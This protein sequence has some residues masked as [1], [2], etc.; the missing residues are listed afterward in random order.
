MTIARPVVAAAVVPVCRNPRSRRFGAQALC[1]HPHQPTTGP[2]SSNPFSLVCQ[3]DP[4]RQ[5]ASISLNKRLHRRSQSAVR[6]SP[7]RPGGQ[8]FRTA[9]PGR[10]HIC[11]Q[12]RP[13]RVAAQRNNTKYCTYELKDEIC[14]S[15]AF[16]SKTRASGDRAGSAD[17]RGRCMSVVRFCVGVS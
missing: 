3:H 2:Q 13:T 10:Q 14:D 4:H 7:G 6:G 16:V 15:R 17:V 11:R 9:P 1:R 5:P 12:T 8:S